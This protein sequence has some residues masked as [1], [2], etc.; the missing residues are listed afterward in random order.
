ML[1]NG[2]VHAQNSYRIGNDASGCPT[3]FLGCYLFNY[4]IDISF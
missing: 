4:K 3:D 1:I 2:D